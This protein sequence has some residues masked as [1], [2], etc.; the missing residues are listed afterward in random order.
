MAVRIPARALPSTSDS[1][2]RSYRKIPS[3]TRIMLGFGIMAYGAIALSVSDK[4]EETLGWTAT[5]EEKE[6][7]RDAL[8]RIRMVDRR[9]DGT[10]SLK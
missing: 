10:E 9:V 3:K 2:H 8:P 6:K 4:A 7:L 5:E 1:L